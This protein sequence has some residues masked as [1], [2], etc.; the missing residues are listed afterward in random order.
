[1][2]PLS[3]LQRNVLIKNI[4][5]FFK[6][7]EQ[8]EGCRNGCPPVCISEPSVFCILPFVPIFPLKPNHR[9]LLARLRETWEESINFLNQNQYAAQPFS[10]NC[11]F[12]KR[13]CQQTLWP[14][15]LSS[16]RICNQLLQC[17]TSG[18]D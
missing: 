6:T 17:D 10:I 13:I 12:L 2:P 8:R 18:W 15:H 5:I 14:L 16:H 4:Y 7:C 11:L 9:I 1:M 3:F